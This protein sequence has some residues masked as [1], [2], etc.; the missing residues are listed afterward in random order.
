MGNT[1][2]SIAMFIGVSLIVGAAPFLG[3]FSGTNDGIAARERL[4]LVWPDLMQMPDRD[5]AL[6]AGLALT[7]QLED[8]VKEQAAVRECLQDAVDSQDARLPYGM[9]R[10]EAEA[11]LNQITPVEPHSR[12]VWRLTARSG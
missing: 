9:N 10:K 1:R 7:C 8:R 2:R 11:R 4:E 5:R 12:S 3:R 6:L